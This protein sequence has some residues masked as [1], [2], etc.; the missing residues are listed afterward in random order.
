MQTVVAWISQYWVSLLLAGGA[1]WLAGRMVRG[2]NP[3]LVPSLVIGFLGWL[4]GL[5]AERLLGIGVHGAPVLVANFLVALAGSVLLWVAIR[6][7][8]RA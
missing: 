5:G 8:K 1:G 6:L 4:L 3:P 7:L 2:H